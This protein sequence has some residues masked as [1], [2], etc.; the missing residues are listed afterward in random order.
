MSKRPTK[1]KFGYYDWKIIYCSA[2]PSDTHGTTS[3]DNKEIVIWNSPNEQVVKETLYHELFHVAIGDSAQL[4][5]N[6]SEEDDEDYEKREEN[7]T[8]LMSPRQMQLFMDNPK[9]LQYIFTKDN[10]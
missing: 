9:L 1:F 5:F 6:Q 2:K 3:Q 10:E 8:R 4:I 7:L